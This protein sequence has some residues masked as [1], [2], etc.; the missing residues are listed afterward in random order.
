MFAETLA[1]HG[2][3][4]LP[5]TPA[6][7][8]VGFLAALL[9]TTSPFAA[10][11]KKIDIPDLC[12]ES[13]ELPYRGLSY[14]GPVAVSNI[15]VHKQKNGFPNMISTDEHGLVNQLELVKTLGSPEYMNTS[16]EGTLQVNMMAG[17]EKYVSKRGYDAVIVWRGEHGGKYTT[18]SE[19]PDLEWIQRQVQYGSYV[20]LCVGYYN[21]TYPSTFEQIYTHYV[22]LVNCQQN[23]N[24]IQIHDP[25]PFSGKEPKTETFKLLPM[26]RGESIQSWYGDILNFK[27]AE[28]LWKLSGTDKLSNG[29]DLAI[30]E[31]AASIFFQDKHHK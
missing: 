15:L 2:Q 28:G 26:R 22:T 25:S 21:Q 17:L 9:V 5:N 3:N 20:I 11:D 19:P 8:P 12:Q 1:L 24:E 23:D 31:G 13:D 6:L 27:S 16:H 14:C 10:E 29:C 18:K 7:L 30:V 4:R